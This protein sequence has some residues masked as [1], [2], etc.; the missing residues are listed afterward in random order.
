[1]PDISPGQSEED[2]PPE[3]F[4][5]S[6][7]GYHLAI[8]NSLCGMAMTQGERQKVTNIGLGIVQYTVEPRG[9]SVATYVE[10][11]AHV[12]AQLTALEL[13]SLE[14]QSEGVM[15]RRLSILLALKD[16]Y[17][18][19]IGQ[20]I[21]FDYARLEFDVSSSQASGDG[22]PLTGWE[23]RVF[24][25]NLGVARGAQLVQEQ[26]E[27][28]CAFYRGPSGETKFV[29][30]QTPRELESWVQFINIDQMIKVIPKL[31]A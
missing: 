17:I 24:T 12:A 14:N 19:A 3:K 18:R 6:M 31:T 16:S 7:I 10:S 15:L 29:W 28:V 26:Y 2:I 11:I 13:R 8:S 22:T 9:T 1:M 27:C 25:A 20:P 30:H 23:F 5:H 4:N 21:G